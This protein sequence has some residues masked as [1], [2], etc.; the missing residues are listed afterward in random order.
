MDATRAVEVETTPFCT[1]AKQL[2]CGSPVSIDSSTDDV[3][4]STTIWYGSS[5]ARQ[6]ADICRALISPTRT[7]GDLR[8]HEPRCRPR[9]SD[10]GAG[11]DLVRLSELSFTRPVLFP[12][13]CPS[14]V[15]SLVSSRASVCFAASF[16][17]T[18]AT[19]LRRAHYCPRAPLL[20]HS[21]QRAG[22]IN[23]SVRLRSAACP[24]QRALAWA[25][26]A[27]KTPAA[28]SSRWAL[29]ALLVRHGQA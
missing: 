27:P 22:A 7:P 25:A 28:R 6:P 14:L 20:A 11:S 10:A 19:E 21:V 26:P 18:E 23:F 15:S 24:G 5:R 2:T 17:A 1:T 13:V 8:R 9:L 29:A 3:P 12:P 16:A 4:L